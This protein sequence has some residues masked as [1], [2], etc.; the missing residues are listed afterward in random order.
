MP[1]GAANSYLFVIS[2]EGR[3]LL[4]LRDGEQ[5]IPRRCAPRNDQLKPGVDNLRFS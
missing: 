4:F 5:Q 1:E 3:N 2:T